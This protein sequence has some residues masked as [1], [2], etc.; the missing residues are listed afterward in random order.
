M[1]SLI[2]LLSAASALAAPPAPAPGPAAA[3]SPGLTPAS[4][5]APL[6]VSLVAGA[7]SLDPRS[8]AAQGLVVAK[9]PRIDQTFGWAP[10]QGTGEGVAHHERGLVYA[11]LKVTPPD[12]A[13][14][15][16][17]SEVAGGQGWSWTVDGGKTVFYGTI[18][19][20]P[21]HRV[22]LVTYGTQVSDNPVEAI[23]Q[24]ALAAARCGG[25]SAAP[26]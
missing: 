10:P 12:P 3:A 14:S 19:D 24:Q 11:A 8:S 1:T 2:L 17:R 9:A 4:T 7:H 13:A 23:H 20:C 25:P 5:P 15:L 22:T 18:F 21:A 26:Q 6:V 16:T